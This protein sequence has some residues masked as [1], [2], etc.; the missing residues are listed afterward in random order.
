MKKNVLKAIFAMLTVWMLLPACTSENEKNP[1]LQAPVA[2]PNEM[3]AAETK[4]TAEPADT[5]AQQENQAEKTEKKKSGKDSDDDD[6]DR[7]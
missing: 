5:T 1:A 2:T 7:K 3:Q 6:D 4:A